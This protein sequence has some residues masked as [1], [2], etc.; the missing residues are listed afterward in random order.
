MDFDTPSQTQLANPPQH[1]G[2]AAISSADVAKNLEPDTCRIC[3]SEGTPQ[4]PLFYPCKCSGSIKYVHQDCLMEWLSHSQKKHCELCKTSFRFTKLY[5]PTMPKQ[6]PVLVFTRHL[7]KYFLRNIVVWLRVL[8]VVFVWLA[9]LPALTRWEWSFFFWVSEEGLV[10]APQRALEEVGGGLNATV[11]AAAETASA[12]AAA[13]A[14]VSLAAAAASSA[15]DNLAG[16]AVN[17]SAAATAPGR[18]ADVYGV[19]DS[20]QTTP[21]TLLSVAFKIVW[22]S[23]STLEIGTIF[24]G[25]NVT[26]AVYTGPP[27]LLSNVPLLR[28]LTRWTWIN[29]AVIYSMEGQFITFLVI[30]CFILIILVR[31]YVLQQQPEI[32]MRAAFNIGGEDGLGAEDAAAGV[33]GVPNDAGQAP[34]PRPPRGPRGQHRHRHHHHHLHHEH[35]VLDHDHLHEHDHHGAGYESGGSNSEWETDSDVEVEIDAAELLRPHVQG[36]ARDGLQFG[37]VFDDDFQRGPPVPDTNGPANRD[38][39][40]ES[41]SSSSSSSAD[42]TEATDANAT[43]ASSSANRAA[44]LPNFDRNFPLPSEGGATVQE[45]MNIYRRADGDQRRI[46]EI[47]REENLEEHL[48]YWLRVMQNVAER[49]QSDRGSTASTISTTAADEDNANNANNMKRPNDAPPRLWNE[50]IQ[51]P[52]SATTEMAR[53][54]SKGKQRADQPADGNTNGEAS[55]STP[56]TEFEYGLRPR[57]NTDGPSGP[58]RINPLANNNW[59]FG[60]VPP[61]QTFTPEFIQPLYGDSAERLDGVPVLGDAPPYQGVTEPREGDLRLEGEQRRRSVSSNGSSRRNSIA[62]GNTRNG[63]AGIAEETGAGSSS[64]EASG[65]VPTP[66]STDS[67]RRNEPAAIPRTGNWADLM[68]IPVDDEANWADMAEGDATDFEDVVD[69]RAPPVNANNNDN[70]HEVVAPHGQPTRGPP[71]LAPPPPPP[72]AA[73]QA[74]AA[75]REAPAPPDSLLGEVANFIWRDL[76]DIDPADLP[77]I[78]PDVE[79]E[80]HLNDILNDDDDEAPI[81]LDEQDRE[82]FEA[83]AAAAAAANMEA[84]AIEDAEDLEGVMELLG[85]RGPI[86][87]LF[88]NVIFCGFLVTVSLLVGIFMPYN[89]GRL[90]IWL[91]ANPMR[92]IMM[93]FSLAKLLQDI[94]AFALGGTAYL[95]LVVFD[96]TSTFSQLIF[97]RAL[98]YAKYIVPSLATT[99]DLLSTSAARVIENF[100]IDAPFLSTGEIRNFSSISHEAL[101]CIKANIGAVAVGIGR[102]IAMIVTGEFLSHGTEALEFVK[103]SSSVAWELLR[104]LPAVLSN[105]GSWV[106]TLDSMDPVQVNPALAYWGG[107]DRS[108]AILFGYAAMCLIAGLYLHR[109]SPFSSGATVQEWEASLI[110]GL[111]QASGVLK[112]I[113]IIGIEMLV[114]PLYCGLLLDVALLPLFE[115]TTLVS[116]LQFSID[117]PLTSIFVHWFVGTGYMFHFALFVSMCRKIMRKGVLYFIRDPDDPE[118]HPVRDVLER[119]VTTQLRKILFSAFVY[120]ALVIICLGGVV[121][122][123]A[124]AGPE[125]LPIHYSSN[126]PVLEFPIDLLFYNF[127]MP[128]AINFFKPSDGLHSMYTWWFRKSARGLRITWFL[129]GERRIDEEGALVLAPDSEDHQNRLWLS[130]QFLEYD[131]ANNR[132]VPMVTRS[133]QQPKDTYEELD[134]NTNA[135][136]NRNPRDQHR[137]I[138]RRKPD[139]FSMMFFGINKQNLVESGQLVPNGKFVRAPASDQVKIP[140]N[141]DVFLEVTDEATLKRELGHPP[142]QIVIHGPNSPHLQ[143]VAAAAVAAAAKRKEEQPRDIYHGKQYELVYIPP[144]FRVRIFLFIASIWMFAAVTGVSFTIIPLLFGRRLFRMVLPDNVRTNDIYAFS[145]GIYVL[146][147]AAYFVFHAN[148]ILAKAWAAT[149]RTLTSTFF[150]SVA[151]T[152]LKAIQRV[153]KVVYAYFFIAIV[154]PLMA[155][156]LVELYLLIP[157]HTYRYPPG[158]Y[159]L[160]GYGFS[161]SSSASTTNESHHTVRIIQSWTLGVLYLKVL[162]RT[163]TSWYPEARL[164]S[165]IRAVLRRGELDPDVRLLTRAFVIPALVLFS[166]A[167]GLPMVS[168][169]GWVAA[170]TSLEFGDTT[171]PPLVQFWLPNAVPE[172]TFADLRIVYRLSFPIVAFLGLGIWSLWGMA[173]VYASWKLR[174]RDEAYLI[175]ERL[176][177]FSVTNAPPSTG[178]RGAFRRA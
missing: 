168:A 101:I 22:K 108:L 178:R 8:L 159:G 118:F 91:V 132:V 120:G 40:S 73:A 31:D 89:V 66:P 1:N 3:R 136:P 129:F 28:T 49:R 146:G 160:T 27:S 70:G 119:S 83:A 74:A 10:A 21:F 86:A 65:V 30:I 88:Q 98:P 37:P 15:A 60:P 51:M 151:M 78:Q 84:E 67:S 102:A 164:T 116:R 175:G 7:A 111:N 127:L 122:G 176:H 19:L 75:N 93:L 161:G 158:S 77:P 133:A 18:F 110:D 24:A 14:S 53:S 42:T 46:L 41:S 135:V 162:S 63:M 32:N 5:S 50:L 117:Y 105:P 100:N 149:K 167:V 163:I 144:Y 26:E 148:S 141:K 128:L 72:P 143:A 169:K 125:I 109:G 104:S 153:L 56:V 33:P 81:P 94:A 114:F 52:D 82:A 174:I 170:A 79:E 68:R 55:S 17:G 140:K 47:A 145:I 124:Y 99:W 147:S 76:D 35:D 156:A 134:L 126:E 103:S 36:P 62:G 90:S 107:G 95:T 138:R 166:V 171:A 137:L 20:N 69:G 123:L 112:V 64:T 12:A 25:D 85:M 177:N 43:A 113:L 45:Y 57:A 115:D 59:S 54:S 121:W 48:Q 39:Q 154:F 165:A 87:G 96:S 97:G 142:K 44:A 150:R 9:L 152:T 23:F 38:E 6:L 155:T 61:T 131:E 157:L 4:E 13:A 11:A 92:P 16:L 34:G 29:K 2:D 172:P 106:I 71:R 80:D 173:G 58:S 139:D 130:K